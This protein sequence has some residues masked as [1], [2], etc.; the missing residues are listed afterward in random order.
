MALNWSHAFLLLHL[1]TAWLRLFPSPF[2]KEDFQPQMKY[3]LFSRF[4][5]RTATERNVSQSS[6]ALRPEE[7]QQRQQQTTPSLL[8]FTYWKSGTAEN[9]SLNPYP[10][11]SVITPRFQPLHVLH[12]FSLGIISPSCTYCGISSSLKW[13]PFFYSYSRAHTQHLCVEIFLRVS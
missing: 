11:W 7:K 12:H 6:G 4:R 1:N 10:S 9:T 5:N 2:L 3:I 8:C 13:R